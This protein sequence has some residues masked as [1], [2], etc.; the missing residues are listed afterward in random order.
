MRVLA[1]FCTGWH[2]AGLPGEALCTPSPKQPLQ[3]QLLSR[4][5]RSMKRET[6]TDRGRAAGDA[7][8]PLDLSQ[9]KEAR[10]EDGCD[11]VL[12]RT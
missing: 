9:K 7:R 2:H 12:W 6:E 8:C 4:D 11:C 5:Q 10:S 3:W 1:S